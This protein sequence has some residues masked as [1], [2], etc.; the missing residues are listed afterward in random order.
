MQGKPT[1]STNSSKREPY[2][3]RVNSPRGEGKEE[4]TPEA[5]KGDHHSR[6]SGDSLSPRRKKQRSDDSLQGGVSKN[7]SPDL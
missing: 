3:K 6:S 4:C 5:P 1:Q 7:K 2:P